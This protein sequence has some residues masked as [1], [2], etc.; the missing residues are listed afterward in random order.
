MARQAVRL[1][2]Y[3]S[4]HPKSTATEAKLRGATLQTQVYGNSGS[5]QQAG[6]HRIPSQEVS[7]YEKPDGGI[8]RDLRNHQAMYLLPTVP[9]GAR[10]LSSVPSTKDQNAGSQR[11]ASINRYLTEGDQ[12]AAKVRGEREGYKSGREGMALY[13]KEWDQRWNNMKEKG[14]KTKK[15]TLY[16]TSG[17]ALTNEVF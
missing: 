10:A 3:S 13:L 6:P 5:V 8:Q 12:T 14:D 4:S 2:N 11:P 1:V 16:P 17:S 7:N 15:S 9:K